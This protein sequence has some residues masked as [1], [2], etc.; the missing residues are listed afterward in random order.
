[1][2]FSYLLLYTCHFFHTDSQFLCLIFFKA[3]VIG[4]T[5]LDSLDDV[6]SD[7]QEE[8]RECSRQQLS[9]EE[10]DAL[11]QEAMECAQKRVQMAGDA[12]AEVL[13]ERKK[14]SV[15]N[16]VIR[17]AHGD[18]KDDQILVKKFEKET[19]IKDQ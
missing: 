15:A 18:G 8:N 19:I 17:D 10:R 6:L 2:Y 7:E 13:P 1:M 12:A 11:D 14:R 9:Q 3:D 16:R 5:A 4:S